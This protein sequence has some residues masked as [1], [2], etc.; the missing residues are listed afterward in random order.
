[1]CRFVAFLHV[2]GGYA[3]AVE[4]HH[5]ASAENCAAS[6]NDFIR[7]FTAYVFLQRSLACL[8]AENFLFFFKPPHNKA[9]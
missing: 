7:Q 4:K 8:D 9:F 3:S 5:T 6:A 1:M 2:T